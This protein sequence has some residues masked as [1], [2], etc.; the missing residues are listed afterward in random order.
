MSSNMANHKAWNSAS[1]Q[2]QIPMSSLNLLSRREGPQPPLPKNPIPIPGS[3]IRKAESGKLAKDENKSEKEYATE[4][5]FSKVD[6]KTSQKATD[7]TQEKE[8]KSIRHEDS[9]LLE[10][11]KKTSQDSRIDP[12]LADIDMS[13]PK[14]EPEIVDFIKKF[15]DGREE[16][17]KNELIKES[18]DIKKELRFIEK[19]KQLTEQFER[20]KEEQRRMELERKSLF[21]Q[22]IEFQQV[23][24]A[25]QQRINE[26][27]KRLEEKHMMCIKMNK[28]QHERKIMYE[29][30]ERQRKLEEDKNNSKKSLVED[31]YIIKLEEI[32]IDREIGAGGSAKVYYGV[33]KEIDVAIKRLNLKSLDIGKARQEFKREYKTLSKIRHPNLVLFM[34]VSLGPRD[35]C[36]ITEY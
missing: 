24:F 15:S 5:W 16:E 21:E 26:E 32:K 22:K 2:K 10:I 28:L 18:E 33:Y 1:R 13:S 36:I 23:K 27:K 14:N 9:F 8:L 20:M 34:G 3:G 30:L 31:H 6:E 25:E 29:K 17:S 11:N 12:S 19:E 35:L 4:D 7:G